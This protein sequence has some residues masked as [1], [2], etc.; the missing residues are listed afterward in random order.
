MKE[1]PTVILSIKAKN[2]ESQAISEINIPIEWVEEN[3]LEIVAYLVVTLKKL[4]KTKKI[5]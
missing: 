3:K 1:L 4:Y 2:I 5:K